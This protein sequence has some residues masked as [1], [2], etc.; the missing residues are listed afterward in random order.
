M[1][2]ILKYAPSC[3]EAIDLTSELSKSS[4]GSSI[5]SESSIKQEQIESFDKNFLQHDLKQEK[6][7]EC[8]IEIKKEPDTKS[9]IALASSYR[10]VLPNECI[11]PHLCNVCWVNDHMYCI[12]MQKIESDLPKLGGCLHNTICEHYI[13]KQKIM[14]QPLDLSSKSQ[15]LTADDKSDLNKSSRKRRYSEGSVSEMFSVKKSR[16]RSSCEEFVTHTKET[17]VDLTCRETLGE[18]PTEPHSPEQPVGTESLRVQLRARA[19]QIVK[20]LGFQ[21]IS[22][23]DSLRDLRNNRIA[24][25]SIKTDHL[26]KFDDA[27]AIVSFISLE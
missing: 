17:P 6:T 21:D 3:S 2:S 20:S 22:P 24:D 4:C 7:Y 5:S 13:M 27:S 8:E 16:R 11:V 25:M 19:S 15:N 1:H 18:S 9:N 14:E 26:G 23:S 10:E 12:G